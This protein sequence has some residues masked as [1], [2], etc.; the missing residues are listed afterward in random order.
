[1]RLF[2]FDKTLKLIFAILFAFGFST[3]AFAGGGGGGGDPLPKGCGN[4]DT[5]HCTGKV[6]R[7]L[8]NYG[9]TKSYARNPS[10]DRDQGYCLPQTA[11]YCKVD[12]D[13]NPC[14][15]D[16]G[17]GC[18]MKEWSW[19]LDLKND[20]VT[21]TERS[22]NQCS[23]TSCEKNTPEPEK[24][25]Y[26]DVSAAYHVYSQADKLASD[27][28]VDAYFY[29]AEEGTNF[30][31]IA[32]CV[33]KKEGKVVATKEC[34]GD[35][36]GSR[37]YYKPNCDSE[38]DCKDKMESWDRYHKNITRFCYKPWEQRASANMKVYEEAGGQTIRF[39]EFQYQ[40]KAG[41][42]GPCE[43]SAFNAPD[44]DWIIDDPEP[45]G[46]LV[47]LDAQDA[48]TGQIKSRVHTKVSGSKNV[49][50][51][52]FEA[53]Q[54]DKVDSG[55]GEVSC[56]IFKDGETT[57]IDSGKAVATLGMNNAIGRTLARATGVSSNF[58]YTAKDAFKI[59]G[60]Y[61]IKCTGTSKDGGQS[62]DDEAEIFV[63]PHS[64][65][66]SNIRAEFANSTYTGTKTDATCPSGMICENLLSQKQTLQHSNDPDKMTK[67]PKHDNKSWARKPVVK[68]GSTITIS[69][70]GMRA[71]NEDGDVDSG[72]S[73]D[74]KIN[75]VLGIDDANLQT[76]AFTALS[77]T[78]ADNVP[79]TTT[80]ASSSVCSPK[81]KYAGQ[82]QPTPISK[83][84]IDTAQ[85]HAPGN[86]ITLSS[87][88]DA[89]IGEAVVYIYDSVLHENIQQQETKGLCNKTNDAENGNTFPC[90]YP[91]RLGLNFEYE[92]TP[93]NFKV[94]VLDDNDNPIKVLYFGQGTSPK[95]E[96]GNK[97][98][99]TA[100]D[101][102][103]NVVETFSRNCAAQNMTL[104]LDDTAMT[105]SGFYFELINK[106]GTDYVI[107]AD[108][109]KQGI[110]ESEVIIK[111]QKG[112][113]TPFTPAM[114][115]EPV[116]IDKNKFPNGFP[117]DMGF[118][119]F[120]AT[121]TYYPNYENVNVN[122]GESMVILRGRINAI[123]TDNGSGNLGSITP[124]KVWYEFQCEY[125]NLDEVA[126]ITG[127]DYSVAGSRSPTQQ[128]WWID[129]TFGENNANLITAPVASI[130]GG[131]IKI[132][133][134]SSSVADGLQ[135]ISYSG[136]RQ[137]THKL[138]I[139][140]GNFVDNAG[141]ALSMPY[142]LLYN[143]Y[144]NGTSEKDN[145]GN[146]TGVL[147]SGIK[148]NTSSFIYIKGNAP[149]DKRNYGVDTDGAKNTRSGGRTGKF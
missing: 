148:W 11:I 5:I 117:V 52:I 143:A 83:G 107:K 19:S 80:K 27:E 75:G 79:P 26:G 122:E 132:G 120:P 2:R 64:Y 118:A 28:P 125:C 6:Y 47:I 38:Q 97:I 63:A 54:A 104:K 25:W 57:A 110:A 74:T 23:F 4:K 108:K 87:D 49:Q 101:S 130:E 66:F 84:I 90:P 73:E 42:I 144:W 123:D 146:D 8:A 106:D 53:K 100:I 139:L 127:A 82:A 3:T 134:V 45:L 9:H 29:C 40:N 128:G 126:K 124:T 136:S 13:G 22:K 71:L 30:N 59:S 62:K 43:Y 99:V 89:I 35:A 55:L 31:T 68:M 17:A 1:M 39:P 121:S 145:K 105:G 78:N 37:Y 109:F 93:F 141:N 112:K 33:D 129:K 36:Q 21:E 56:S 91:T 111:V 147:T 137:G 48:K 60:K 116:I 95:V 102:D 50:F 15:D 92:I 46:D 119:N 77:I 24:F 113:D 51:R 58:I 140:H 115:S 142:F 138:N 67:S 114:K 81:T 69:I 7:C 135:T 76:G 85:G 70:A 12:K 133:S 61:T 32:K 65:E 149:D 72:V 96:K 131:G 44:S 16:R 18:G 10:T 14:A 98:R 94:E 103:K 86:I 41:Y 34:E 20:K 88:T